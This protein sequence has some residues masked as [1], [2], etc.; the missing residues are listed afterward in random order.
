[1]RAAQFGVC[2]SIL[3]NSGALG[4]GASPHVDAVLG[5]PMEEHED[6]AV[7]SKQVPLGGRLA[8]AGPRPL[9]VAPWEPGGG[10]IRSSSSKCLS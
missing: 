5:S 6:N 9:S 8:C 2:S 10:G 7:F 4:T 1:M 3:E